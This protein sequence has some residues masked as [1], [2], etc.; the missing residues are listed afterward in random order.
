MFD[1]SAMQ[2]FGQ[3]PSKHNDMNDMKLRDGRQ[4]YEYPLQKAMRK[5]FYPPTSHVCR[6]HACKKDPLVVRVFGLP[7]AEQEREASGKQFMV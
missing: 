3:A 1:V 7:P 5:E 2:A 6:K 4:Q